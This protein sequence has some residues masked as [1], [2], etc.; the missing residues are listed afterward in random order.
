[1]QPKGAQL[2]TQTP[3]LGLDEIHGQDRAPHIGDLLGQAQ[4]GARIAQPEPVTST[5]DR[6]RRA[7]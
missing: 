3:Q 4:V 7:E 1:M 5:P 2:T 6:R